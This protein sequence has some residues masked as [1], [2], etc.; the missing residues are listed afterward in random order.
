MPQSD[1]V[2]E[3]IFSGPIRPQQLTFL[4]APRTDAS[5]LAGGIDSALVDF[6]ALMKTEVAQFDELTAG[7]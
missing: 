1:D 3:K 5:L 2:F 7:L 4:M 6:D